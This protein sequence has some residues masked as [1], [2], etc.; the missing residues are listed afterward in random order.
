MLPYRAIIVLPT[1][2]AIEAKWIRSTGSPPEKTRYL[3]VFNYAVQLDTADLDNIAEAIKKRRLFQEVSITKS[4]NPDK[5]RTPDDVLTIYPTI[6]KKKFRDDQWFVR[7]PSKD[8][9]I[10]IYYDVT[11]PPGRARLVSLL[12]YL[13][14]KVVQELGR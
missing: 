2:S 8:D 4:S 11:L 7:I 9:A 14:R 1:Q 3:K 5:Y 10:P 6:G 13:E 12:D